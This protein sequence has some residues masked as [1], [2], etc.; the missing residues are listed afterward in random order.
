MSM[1]IT[2]ASSSQRLAADRAHHAAR[3]A[4]DQR[5]DRPLARLERAH[6]AAVAA[7]EEERAAEAAVAQA[8]LEVAD[9]ARHAR[10][11]IA[12][13]P[14]VVAVRSYSRYSCVTWCE[15]RHR[16]VGKRGC[17]DLATRSS[18]SGIRV[19]VQ[20]ADRDRLDSL[21]EELRH[22]RT[23][24]VLVERCQHR[25]V[26]ARPARSPPYAGRAGRAAPADPSGAGTSARASARSR[27]RRGSR[28]W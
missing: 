28:A 19:G 22:D 11:L 24:L 3:R 4:R 18:W 25:P 15:T 12:A 16:D 9:V 21:G 2:F 5:A 14:T 13:S 23:H 10:G 6:D 7:R 20:E 26:G 1:P 8:Q 17:D 27:A